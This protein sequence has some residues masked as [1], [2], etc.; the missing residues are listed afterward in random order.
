[1]AGAPIQRQVPS[2]M[3]TIGQ[4]AKKVGK[5]SDTVRRWHR[6]GHLPHADIMQCGQLQ[7]YLF[8]RKGLNLARRLAEGEGWLKDRAKAA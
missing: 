3:Y 1:M 6:L 4:V 2:G 7:V 8:D 5:P